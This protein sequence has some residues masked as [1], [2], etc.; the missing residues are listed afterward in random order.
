MPKQSTRKRVSPIAQATVNTATIEVPYCDPRQNGY[1]SQVRL[2]DQLHVTSLSQR[3]R[4]AMRLLFSGLR[5]N[6]IEMA[7]KPI[8]HQNDAIR[9]LLERLAD[10]CNIP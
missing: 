3:Q 6:N 4:E 10:S 2:H 9:Y 5:Q 8:I 1:Q 7:G